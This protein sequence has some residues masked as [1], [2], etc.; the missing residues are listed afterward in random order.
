MRRL[1]RQWLAFVVVVGLTV[2]QAGAAGLA[3][4]WC[5][6]TATQLAAEQGQLLTVQQ[7]LGAQAAPQV[8]VAPVMD[9]KPRWQLLDGPDVAATLETI[10]QLGTEAK[11]TFGSIKAAQSNT[12]GKQSFQ[13]SGWGT[14]A[15]VCWFLAA[16]EHGG[17]LVIVESGRIVPGGDEQISFELGLA[18][19]HGGRR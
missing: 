14:P 8:E 10:N 12:V 3:H 11:V 2:V 18:T 16:V 6:A 5:A 1:G 17:R 19:Y 7:Q 9:T 15:Q 4:F 13:V